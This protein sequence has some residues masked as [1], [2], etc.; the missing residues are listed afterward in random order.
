[1]K[2]RNSKSSRSPTQRLPPPPTPGISK[3][4]RRTK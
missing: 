4:K 2:R 1:L 3:L